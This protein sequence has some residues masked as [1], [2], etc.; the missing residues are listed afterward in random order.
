M[1]T[2]IATSKVL[3]YSIS[4]SIATIAVGLVLF[5]FNVTDAVL[6]I[7]IVILVLSPLF[8]IVVTTVFLA[9][10]RDRKW[11]RVA[12]AL[13]AVAAAGIVVSYFF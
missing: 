8:G 12:I 6:Y 9:K 13:I 4:A 3:K 7:G 1:K 2:E 11:L 5:L 10:E